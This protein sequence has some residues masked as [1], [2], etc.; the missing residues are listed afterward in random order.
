MISKP[1]WRIPTAPSLPDAQPTRELPDA[2][3][4]AADDSVGMSGAEL[5]STALSVLIVDPHEVSRAAI[6]ALLQTEGLEVA[7]VATGEQALAAASEKRADVVIIDTRKNAVGGARLR[8]PER[9]RER[10]TLHL[11]QAI[12]PIEHRPQQPEQPRERQIGFRLHPADPEHHHPRR[13]AGGVLQQRRLADSSLAANHQRPTLASGS[14]IH[15][16]VELRAL[17]ISADQSRVRRP[18]KPSNRRVTRLKRLTRPSGVD[19]P[20]GARGVLRSGDLERYL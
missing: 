14:L 11:E 15:E 19:R 3:G 5:T 16:L 10:A 17:A 8:Q 1:A 9:T 13:P 20:N 18:R 7:D 6:R 12:E 4:P 2:S